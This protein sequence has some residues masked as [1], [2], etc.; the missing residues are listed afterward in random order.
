MSSSTQITCSSVSELVYHVMELLDMRKFTFKVTGGLWA[1]ESQG[2]LGRIWS[3][4]LGR[5]GLES[6]ADLEEK[7]RRGSIDLLLAGDITLTVLAHYRGPGHAAWESFL[8]AHGLTL[9]PTTSSY[10]CPLKPGNG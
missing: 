7:P 3:V 5:I 1:S 10:L 9:A 6:I 2:S 8:A 4:R